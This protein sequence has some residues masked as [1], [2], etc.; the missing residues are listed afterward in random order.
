MKLKGTMILCVVFVRSTYAAFTFNV[1]SVPHKIPNIRV[2]W[3][4]RW[5]TL[6]AL[7]G[8][9]VEWCRFALSCV[10]STLGAAKTVS[11]TRS[12]YCSL[13]S[14]MWLHVMRL[15]RCVWFTT[16]VPSTLYPTF[17]LLRSVYPESVPEWGGMRPGSWRWIHMFLSI[18][19]RRD[20]VRNRDLR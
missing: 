6:Q 17:T 7:T 3:I 1:E 12:N 16:R 13:S 20:G 19:V 8:I 4:A 15:S 14:N 18:W 5:K 2:V 9:P 10:M 11:C